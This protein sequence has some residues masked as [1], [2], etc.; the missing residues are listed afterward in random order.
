MRHARTTGEGQRQGRGSNTLPHARARA[1]KSSHKPSKEPAARHAHSCRAQAGVEMKRKGD[2]G[3]RGRRAAPGDQPSM[4]TQKAP[5]R[6]AAVATPTRTSIQSAMAESMQSRGTRAQAHAK[7]PKGTFE[8][9]FGCFSGPFKLRFRCD[10][11]EFLR[12]AHDTDRQTQDTRQTPK[13]V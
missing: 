13:Q 12:C 5:S 10:S 11:G 4:R 9:R 6:K 1:R 7:V 8:E 2:E 3:G